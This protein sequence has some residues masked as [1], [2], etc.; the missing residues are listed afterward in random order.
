MNHRSRAALAVCAVSAAAGALIGL[1]VLR[2][3]SVERL[4]GWVA[5]LVFTAESVVIIWRRRGR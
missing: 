3:S 5:A 4:I 1:G 2:V